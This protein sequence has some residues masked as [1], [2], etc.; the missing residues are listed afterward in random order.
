MDDPEN[1]SFDVFTA[2]HDELKFGLDACPKM[3]VRVTISREE[4]PVWEH[5][6]EVAANMAVATNGG[7]PIAVY[8]RY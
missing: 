3:W 4:F 5:A 7:M 2:L 8:P 6:Y 1:W